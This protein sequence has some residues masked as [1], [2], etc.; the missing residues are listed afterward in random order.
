MV[1]PVVQLVEVG[2]GVVLAAGHRLGGSTVVTLAPQRGQPRDGGR[3][4][5]VDGDRED[6]H[7]LQ[8]PGHQDAESALAR[9]STSVPDAARSVSHAEG[10][11][12]SP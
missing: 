7:A 2:R 10:R 5:E 8:R 3:P 9:S 6:P 4:R 1:W 11:N 12:R